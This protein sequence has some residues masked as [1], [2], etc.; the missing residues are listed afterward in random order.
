MDAI[1]YDL[2]RPFIDWPARLI[3]SPDRERSDQHRYAGEKLGLESLYT[4]HRELQDADDQRAPHLFSDLEY[5]ARVARYRDELRAAAR[6]LADHLGSLDEA[7]EAFRA[8]GH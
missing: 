4:W 3:E 7:Q 8:P 5:D 6:R 2:D 1:V